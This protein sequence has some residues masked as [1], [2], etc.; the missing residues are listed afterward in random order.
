M[1][2]PSLIA[3]LVL[4]SMATQ[5]SISALLSYEAQDT[6]LELMSEKGFTGLATANLLA[7]DGPRPIYRKDLGLNH[8]AY[9]EI[10]SGDGKEYF[11]LSAGSK[12]GDNRFVESGEIN[13]EAQQYRPT[14]ALNKQAAKNRQTCYKHYRLSQ[15]GLYMC[16]DRRGIPVAATYNW[17]SDAPIDT[18]QWK[19]LAGM[20]KGS[21]TDFNKEWREL[22]CEVGKEGEWGSLRYVESAQKT[23]R[24]GEEALEAGAR[25][26]VSLG[27]SGHQ[28][29][30]APRIIFT[31]TGGK[32]SD[33]TTAD[34]Q[35]RLCQALLNVCSSKDNTLVNSMLFRSGRNGIN[36]FEFSV[37]QDKATV[38]KLL[39]H[40]DVSFS[41]Q[42][43]LSNGAVIEKRFGIET[44]YTS[45]TKRW[46]SWSYWNIH[47]P[48]LLPNYN[49]HRCCGCYS[50]CGPVAWAQIFAYYDR[51]AHISSGYGYNQKLYQGYHGV[52]GSAAY[53]PPGYTPRYYV[54]NIRAQVDTFCLFGGGATTHWDMTDSKLWNWYRARQSPL[55]GSLSSYTSGFSLPGIYLTWI[56]NSA[57]NAI[58]S[59]YPA[60]VGIW[61]G[62][63]QHYAVA[64]HYR[65]R[66]KKWRICWWFFG[67]HCTKWFYIH[68]H[69][70]YLRMGW[71]GS[72]N[73]WRKAKA[74][75]AFVARK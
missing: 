26:R 46:S 19:S 9:Y 55:G 57:I 47:S 21:L 51:L 5:P 39:L 2:I 11:L 52:S 60:I 63:S 28:S 62:L 75:S 24:Y 34:W 25:H 13:A 41:V 1:A 22:S 31:G 59:R 56:R 17:T 50:G 43:T 36:Y 42:V 10:L 30:A 37:Q 73:T 74:F 49:Q 70:W 72:G 32:K 38:Q 40:T 35:K 6:V 53:Q 14:D 23:K 71:G 54:E 64:T 69:E 45:R 27:L 58:K 67:W 66:H 61:V 15:A 12:S 68:Q 18:S 4:V 29:K 7:K 48:H 44:N 33:L 8:V 65:T 20:M 3:V 16:E